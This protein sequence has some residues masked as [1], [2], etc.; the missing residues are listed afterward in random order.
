MVFHS[1]V[2]DE[3]PSREVAVR[4]RS[5]ST[6]SLTFG[7]WRVLYTVRRFWYDLR[8]SSPE[9]FQRDFCRDWIALGI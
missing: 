4:N 8:M 9:S 6:L 7:A 1:S 5:T 2:G 3:T